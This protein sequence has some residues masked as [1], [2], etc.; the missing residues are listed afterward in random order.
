VQTF[1]EDIIRKRLGDRKLGEKAGQPN[2]ST[3]AESC[4]LDKLMD[5]CEDILELR[6]G[7]LTLLIAGIDSVASL[8]STTTFLLARHQHAQE[9]L[10]SSVLDKV[11]YDVPT[12][13][14]LRGIAYLRYVFNESK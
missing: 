8:L 14:D 6:D 2:G 13:D 12:F 10:R 3:T 5:G 4:F 9:K 11:G 1:V 7:V